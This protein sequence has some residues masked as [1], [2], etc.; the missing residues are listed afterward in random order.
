MKVHHCLQNDAAGFMLMQLMLRRGVV[1]GGTKVYE[2]RAGKLVRH[3]CKCS[4]NPQAQT[5]TAAAVPTATWS[6]VLRQAR[7]CHPNSVRWECL[8]VV[9]GSLILFCFD[10]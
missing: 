3:S 7:C 8:I 6:E 2:A 9:A 10:P 4:A 1:T 5:S